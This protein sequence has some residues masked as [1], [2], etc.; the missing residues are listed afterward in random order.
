MQETRTARRRVLN[1]NVPRKAP[2]HGDS[3][4]MT[5]T[6]RRDVFDTLSRRAKNARMT[7]SYYAK[8]LLEWALTHY[9]VVED[10]TLLDRIDRG[11]A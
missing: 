2:Y 6:L 1:P 8:H 9:P 4:P 3:V 11:V 7:R 5:Y 10:R